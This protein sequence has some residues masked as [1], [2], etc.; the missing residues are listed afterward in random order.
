VKVQPWLAIHPSLHNVSGLVLAAVVFESGAPAYSPRLRSGFG[1][2]GQAFSKS[3]RSGAPPVI[4]VNVK[5]QTRVILPRL[6]GPL[7]KKLPALIA[8]HK[9]KAE[10]TKKTT[11]KI[12]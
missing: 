9:S 10:P 5:R 2:T 1:K 8:E 12:A 7:L 3:A 4:S 6:S 11:D